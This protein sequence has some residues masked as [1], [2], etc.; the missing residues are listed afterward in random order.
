MIA[1]LFGF[2]ISVAAFDN[3]RYQKKL[4][5]KIYIQ[6]SRA[7]FSFLNVRSSLLHVTPFLSPFYTRRLHGEKNNST[8]TIWSE[9]ETQAHQEMEKVRE[10]ESCFDATSKYNN[11]YC[12]HVRKRE[13]DNNQFAVI[14]AG[15]ACCA[16]AIL[17][18]GSFF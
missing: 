5:E 7:R 6:S 11:F 18:T 1:L 17:L 12:E 16:I 14:V 13:Q 8:T 2:C 3:T 10:F 9:S 4:F 15:F